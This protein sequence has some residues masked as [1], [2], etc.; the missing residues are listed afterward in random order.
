M[1]KRSG[2]TNPSFACGALVKCLNELKK[3]GIENNMKLPGVHEP[4]DVEYS[5]LKQR[6]ARI[7]HRK[8][9]DILTIDLA[10]ITK[11]AEEQITNDLETLISKT[12]DRNRADYA[13]FTGIQIHTW[14]TPE[15]YWTNEYILPKSSYY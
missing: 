7:I 13:V 14:D 4:D 12:V 3:E 9:L 6:L 5:I 11:L 2:Q 8:K 15:N 1:V 10:D